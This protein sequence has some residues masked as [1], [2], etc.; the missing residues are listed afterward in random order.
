MIIN[1]KVTPKA[2]E[3]KITRL[4]D[5]D[6]SIRTTSAPDKNRA[7]EAVIKL[8][9]KELHL[10]KSSLH[11]IKGATSRQKQILIDN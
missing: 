10:P 11:I 3:N 8:L 6:F 9:A 2:R 5:T 4:S 7:N 1:V